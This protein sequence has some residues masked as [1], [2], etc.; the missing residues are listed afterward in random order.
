MSKGESARAVPLEF[1]KDPGKE[2]TR[3]TCANP[4]CTRHNAVVY[5][6][7]KDRRVQH[8]QTVFCCGVGGCQKKKLRRMSH[9]EAIPKELKTW[10]EDVVKRH[11]SVHAS[12]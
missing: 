6:R 4:L 3:W 1:Q 7:A 8:H 10:A 5:F 12:P 2:Y 9:A 11:G